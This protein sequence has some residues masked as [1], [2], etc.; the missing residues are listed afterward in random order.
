MNRITGWPGRLT[1]RVLL[2]AGYI[3]GTGLLGYLAF[4][5]WGYDDP[6][7]TYRYASNLAHGLGFVYNPG[8]RILSTTSPLFTLL[9]ASLQAVLQWLPG[10][11]GS[12][13]LIPHLARLI[14]ALSLPLGGLCLWDIGRRTGSAGIRWAGLL[15][16][17]TFP[18]LVSTLSSE[19]PICL[20]FCLAALVCYT[21][22][23]YTLTA[24]CAGLAI[25]TRPD[26]VLIVIP[27]L[28]DH[29]LHRRPVPWK[30]AGLYLGLI[31]AW[32]AFAW[33]YFG[34]PLPV[35]LVAKQ[36]QGS[37][38]GSTRFAPGIFNILVYYT[39]WPYLLAGL[40]SL[41]GLYHYIAHRP[42]PSRPALTDRPASLLVLDW[43]ILYFTAYTILGV[44]RYFW[45]YAPLVAPFL[46]ALGLGIDWLTA[47]RSLSALR[48]RLLAAD[49]AL[50]RSP[51]FQRLVTDPASTLTFLVIA[52]LLITQSRDL[53]L[54]RQSP[55]P[56]PEYY[57]PVGEWLDSNLPPQATVGV[58]EVG[59]IGYYANRPMIDFAGLIQ[60]DIAARLA[61]TATYE[62]AA[63]WAVEHYQP[64]Y[65]VLFSEYFPRL[66]D[67]YASE[68]CQ[69]ITTFPGPPSPTAHDIVVYI[70]TN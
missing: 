20:A 48:Q 17:P 21:R 64:D 8:Q 55:D 3:L 34:S 54:M 42:I 1:D 39:A 57:R 35:T 44:T 32:V 29:L 19:T 2:A 23:R 68:H 27:L 36:S 28:V 52:V 67:G 31:L 11:G 60:P 13:Q 58:Q 50:S 62:E 66:E 61:T 41:A 70:C 46:V 51:H 33:A 22:Q 24:L 63:I 30:A 43:G 10:L 37:L 5:Q 69:A 18:L 7:I 9:L 14:G 59:I 4:S 45:Y 40:L 53:W 49:S 12:Q 25:L 38:V 15:L 16:Y 26:G 6:F 47:S 65:L 56:R